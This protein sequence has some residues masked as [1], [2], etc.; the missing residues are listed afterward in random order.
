MLKKENLIGAIVYYDGLHDD[1]RM[2]LSLVLTA[3][4]YG[5]TVCNH[6]EVIDLLKNEGGRICGVSV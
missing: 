6:T 3:A 2:N 5:A 4:R 1:A